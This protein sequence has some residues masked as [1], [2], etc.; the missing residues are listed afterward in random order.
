M[1]DETDIERMKR[2]QVSILPECNMKENS[3]DIQRGKGEVSGKENGSCGWRSNIRRDGKGEITRIKKR[4]PFK[5]VFQNPRQEKSQ[6]T[7]RCIILDAG[8][9]GKREKFTNN[10]CKN[11]ACLQKKV[12]IRVNYYQL[13]KIGNYPPNLKF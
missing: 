1:R 13:R 8:Y 6:I 4:I 7:S 2:P 3:R 11:T 12:H 5:I 10:L 9:Q